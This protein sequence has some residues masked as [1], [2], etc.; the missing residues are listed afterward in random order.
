MPVADS[1]FAQG[2]ALSRL[3]P[4]FE[5]RPGQEEMARAVGRVLEHGGALMVEAG[6]GTGKT[7]A[8][9]VPALESG[10]RVIVSTGT[11][12]LQDQIFAK[13]LPFL[14]DRVGLEVSATLMKGRENYLCR[15]RFAEF[16][17]APLLEV[18]DERRWIPR[19]SEWSR[20]TGSGDRAE[21]GDLP[22]RLRLWKDVNA[23]ADTCG[24]ARCEEFDRCWLTVMKRSAQ[25]SQ[26]LV[27]N[28]HLFFADLALRT[29]YGAVLPDY[30]AV[31]FDEAHLLEEIATLY[32]GVQ[33]SAAQIEDLARDAEALS[34]RTRG[35]ATG[36]GGAAGLR[37]AAAEFFA[38][39]RTI[40]ARAQGRMRFDPADRGGP[41][42]DEVASLLREAFEEVERQAE[43]AG[44]DEAV[45]PLRRR[46]E[47][48][49]GTLAH[50]LARRDPSFV[51]GIE[52][53]G[54]SNVVLSASPIDVSARLRE[55][56]FERLHACVLT[57]AT[58][59][60]DGEFGFFQT[61]LGA[62]GAQ[63]LVVESPFDHESQA[64]LYL[65]PDMPDPRDADF[66]ARCEE[67]IRSLLAITGG[68]A[69]LLFT[70][71]AA[72]QRMRVALQARGSWTLF[73][74]GEGSRAALLEEF[75]TTAR[76]VLLGTASFWH[77]VDVPG[78][79][80]SLV[81][82]DR[83]PFDV[84]DE[85]L[86]AARIARIREEGGNPFREYQTPLAVLELKQG[87][88]RLLRSRTDRGILCVL[89]PRLRSKPYGK[90]FLRSLPP[91]R[92]VNTVAECARFMESVG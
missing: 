25:G 33:L 40:L 3:H 13:D 52:A 62:E 15:R 23:R 38:P 80:L 67:E 71:H 64:V 11:K 89:D 41:D 21:I 59:A 50:V 87:L 90:V 77:G 66:A 35:G 10:R 78:E 58:L 5:H 82:I 91:Y 48:L 83:L 88:G 36:A 65:P 53:R 74:Q 31:I 24:G 6:T 44:Q 54:K 69:F 42:L 1:F 56:L 18:L 75:R 26:I 79:A 19:L 4:S 55:S 63:T 32:F 45:E 84:P 46:A 37:M 81:V 43:S 86:V 17:R 51:Y 85:P 39:L 34:A 9:L 76:A 7:L 49:R 61:R 47:E 12:N 92:R 28:H 57:S 22:D 16:E 73:V 8:Y 29:A 70:S 20:A 60:V 2:G 27:V 68:R 30:D 14:R 72:L